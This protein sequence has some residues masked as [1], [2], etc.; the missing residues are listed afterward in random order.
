[1]K[2][3]KLLESLTKRKVILKEVVD[4][5]SLK[6]QLLGS[7][8]PKVGDL[9]AL[10]SQWDIVKQGLKNQSL[11]NNWES[12]ISNNISKGASVVYTSLMQLYN[13]I[14]LDV[15]VDGVLN[16]IVKFFPNSK[17]DQDF[18]TLNSEKKNN[19][20]LNK[21]LALFKTYRTN[22]LN[23]S[24]AAPKPVTQAQTSANV[25]DDVERFISK[26]KKI[27]YNAKP[28]VSVAFNRIL[29]S[30]T[31]PKTNDLIYTQRLLDNLNSFWNTYQL[32]NVYKKH[33]DKV[34]LDLKNKQAELDKSKVNPKDLTPYGLVNDNF[35][36]EDVDSILVW[37]NYLK[38]F[39]K[40]KIS[41]APTGN[42]TIPSNYTG[43]K[44]QAIQTYIRK[45][46]ELTKLKINF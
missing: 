38:L 9:L 13:T 28:V 5:N 4:Y 6:S 19:I 21:A 27:L 25:Q 44:L 35:K 24:Q 16:A 7:K 39:I 20:T 31:D 18:I 14:P 40:S 3:I 45:L 34:N 10:Q 42:Y 43:E 29:D 41:F 8:D 36:K 11:N 12:I 1:M 46:E 30:H 32:D 15:M 2:E 22:K 37:L 23:V 26:I 33:V 17:T